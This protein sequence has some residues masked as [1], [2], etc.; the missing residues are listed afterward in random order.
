MNVLSRWKNQRAVYVDQCADQDCTASM[1]DDV[2]RLFARM[3]YEFDMNTF[4]DENILLLG[5]EKSEQI[6]LSEIMASAGSER[7][8]F[9]KETETLSNTQPVSEG[10][11]VIIINLN[12]FDNIL[13]AVDTLRRFREQHPEIG[14]VLV[15]SDVSGDDLSRERAP[16]CDATLRAPL[17][18][19]RVKGALL[20]AA[21]ARRAAKRLRAMAQ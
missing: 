13:I 8:S 5:F 19:Q 2:D 17:S 3:S 15:S 16:I 7:F 9:G 18:T 1:L 14:I 12:S 21:E 10:W 4:A 11:S 20:E 6:E